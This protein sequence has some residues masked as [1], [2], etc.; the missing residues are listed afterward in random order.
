MNDS[1]PASSGFRFRD[2]LLSAVKNGLTGKLEGFASGEDI[3][4]AVMVDGR[5]AWAICRYQP[6][7]LGSFLR[8]LGHVTKDQLAKASADYT[9]KNGQMKLGRILEDTG[10][11]S[12]SVLRRCLLLHVRMALS[13]MLRDERLIGMWTAGDFA[14]DEENSFCLDEVFPELQRGTKKSGV[15]DLGFSAS[16]FLDELAVTPGYRSSVITDSWGSA[17]GIHGDAT[18]DP[19]QASVLATAAATLVESG[20]NTTKRSGLGDLEFLMVEGENGSASIRW[21]DS[22]R[23]FLVAVFLESGGQTGVARYRIATCAEKIQSAITEFNDD[24]E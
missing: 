14:F 6:E 7:D 16:S 5:L 22:E 17:L 12:R 10:I 4:S 19:L 8:R 2:E 21:A 1:S 13:C 9:K 11:V 3:G 24:L 15:D 18:D 20:R 23:R